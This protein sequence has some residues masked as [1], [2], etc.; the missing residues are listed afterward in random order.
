VSDRTIVVGAGLSGLSAAWAISKSGGN[1]EVLEA[2]GRAGGVV[3]T[4]RRDGFLVELGPNT[5]RP[6]APLWDLVSALGLAGEALFADPRAPRYVDFAGELHPL[7]MGFLA[8]RRSRLLSASGKWRLLTE[9]FRRSA[10]ADDDESVAD[11]VRRRLGPEA[12]ERLVEP[13]VAGVFA[14]SANR[15]SAAA[16][17][18]RLVRWER[19]GG[20]LVRGAFSDRRRSPRPATRPPRGLLSFRD[21]LETLPRAL[22]AAL[23]PAF[24][25]EAAVTDLAPKASGGWTV[26]VNGE[27][28]DADRVLLAA[29]AHAAARLV[30]A[31][32]PDAASALSAIPQP[33]LAVLHLSWPEASLRRPL[34]GFGHLVCPDPSRRILG[35]V[36]SSSLFPGR[37]PSGRVLLTVFLG[38]TRDPDAPSLSDDALTALAARDLEAEGIVRGEP[39]R[40]LL[41]RW[42]RAIPQYERGHAARIATV[43]AAEARWPG[44]RF[45]GNYRGGISVGDVVASALDAPASL[46]LGRRGGGL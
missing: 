1:V 9:P 38:G 37:A 14:G 42:E 39:E 11:F 4:E 33:A 41:T 30:A 43:A 40:V 46:G 5:V 26:S 24:R 19:E 3:R 16:A 32:A 18:P 8:F 20:S 35:A 25:P 15:L 22:E 31:F 34:D 6:T 2:S 12:A 29:P 44:L 23:G 36:W 28:R 13:F 10:P 45:L 7:P 27:R 17:F 21:G